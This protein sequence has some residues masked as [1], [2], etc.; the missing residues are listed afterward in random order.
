MFHSVRGEHNMLVEK[1]TV[2]IILNDNTLEPRSAIFEPEIS[3]SLL[4]KLMTS[5]RS[6]HLR[7]N[8]HHKHYLHK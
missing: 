2:R 8:I 3:G 5:L 6:F 7:F 4:F 1:M